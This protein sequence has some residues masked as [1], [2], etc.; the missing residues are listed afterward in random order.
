MIRRWLG[1]TVAAALLLG[2]CAPK[3][4]EE[5]AP[6]TGGKAE[7]AKDAG[8]AKPGKKIK[9]GFA[10]VGAE[11]GWRTANTK[12]IKDEAEKRGI[13]LMFDDA[14]Q[15]QENQIKAIKAFIAAK[16]DV[17]M[18]SPV[19]A[20]LSCLLYNIVNECGVFLGFKVI[21]KRKGIFR[22]YKIFFIAGRKCDGWI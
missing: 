22:H 1:L 12:S 3:V 14:Q 17:I 6:P 15:K 5:P 8:G 2:G 9:V 4:T 13:E 21:L 19:G 11:S 10:Q 20:Y 16:V 7:P 18:F